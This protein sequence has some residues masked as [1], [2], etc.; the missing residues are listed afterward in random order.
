MTPEADEG[1]L[2]VAAGPFQFG[3]GAAQHGARLRQFALP[4]RQPFV[5]FRLAGADRRDRR[6]Q[7][8]DP[9]AVARDRRGQDPLAVADFF[10]PAFGRFQLFAEVG[11]MRARRPREE[12]QGEQRGESEREGDGARRVAGTGHSRARLEER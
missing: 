10:E 7:L 12:Q 6:G 8:V 5:R 4:D 9:V 2:Q 3:F 1:D 11:G